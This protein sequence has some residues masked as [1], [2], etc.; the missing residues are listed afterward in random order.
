MINIKR[1]AFDKSLNQTK[2]GEILRLPQPEVSK[3]MN[4]RRDITQAHIDLLTEHF[5]Q[6]TIAQ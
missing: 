4:G 5:G 6:D 2:L 1:L 3:I